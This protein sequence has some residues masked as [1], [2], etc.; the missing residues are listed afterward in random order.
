MQERIFC[1]LSLNLFITN[2]VSVNNGTGIIV[3]ASNRPVSGAIISGNIV[4]GSV[5][6]EIPQS[7]VKI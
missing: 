2:T 6:V 7:Q 3:S 4:A 5:Q 1:L